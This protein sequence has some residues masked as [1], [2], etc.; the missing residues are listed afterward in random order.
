M[1]LSSSLTAKWR[2]V[3]LEKRRIKSRLNIA[4]G[5]VGR[6]QTAR[7]PVALSPSE[8][9]ECIPGL[10]SAWPE[11]GMQANPSVISC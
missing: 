6:I 2:S 4:L 10:L 9:L 5:R 3:G 1:A 11:K 8:F 7:L